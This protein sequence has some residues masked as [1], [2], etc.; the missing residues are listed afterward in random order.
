LDEHQ[1]T[2]GDK[3][4]G[5][6][7]VTELLHQLA[8]DRLEEPDVKKDVTV[9][10]VC[11]NDKLTAANNLTSSKYLKVQ[12]TKYTNK[13]GKKNPQGDNPLIHVNPT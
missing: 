9:V 3:G 1:I 11:E 7:G 8:A 4:H 5:D 12:Y 10:T 2:V 6:G 13:F